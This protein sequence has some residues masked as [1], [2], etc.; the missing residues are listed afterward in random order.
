MATEGDNTCYSEYKMIEI[1]ADSA[2]INIIGDDFTGFVYSL[3]TFTMDT[4]KEI[5]L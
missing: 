4:Y 5:T 2:Y 1:K 3:D